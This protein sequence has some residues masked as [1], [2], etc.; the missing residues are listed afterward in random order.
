MKERIIEVRYE[1]TKGMQLQTICKKT[2]LLVGGGD[3]CLR[4]TRF[5]GKDMEKQVVKCHESNE[6]IRLRQIPLRKT[7]YERNRDLVLQKA[8][9]KR[10]KQKESNETT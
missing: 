6:P 8:A 2:E 1:R 7:Y 3:C 4:C 10:R 9:D 5:R